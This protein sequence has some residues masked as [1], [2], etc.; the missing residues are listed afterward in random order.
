MHIFFTVYRPE[1]ENTILP[2]TWHQTG[3]SVW[4]RT[5]D[6][7]YEAQMVAGLDAYHFS[8]SNWIQGG[9]S[10]PFEFEVANKYGFLLRVDNYTIPGLRI[11]VSG[12]AGQSMHNNIP[13]DSE[14]GEKKKIKGNVYV[15]SV[16]FTYNRYNWIVRGNADYGYVS[17]ANKI[18][19]LTYPNV[20]YVKPYQSGNGKNFGSHA[21]AMMLEAGY[22]VFSQIKK[23]RSDNQKLYIFGHIEHYDSYVHGT[24]KQWTN[25]TIF[26]GGVNYH[27]VPQIAIKA[28]YHYRK[29][30]SGYNDEP[31]VNIGIAYEGFFL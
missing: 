1:G 29:L 17:D 2:C 27:P 21:M 26:A 28:E 3:V 10:T 19:Q 31:S 16:D 7:R 18:S 25:K 22:D 13:H 11:G 14:R 5:G 12:Y 15:G 9:S 4:G 20:Q 6:F 23:L 30:K 8:R 24:T